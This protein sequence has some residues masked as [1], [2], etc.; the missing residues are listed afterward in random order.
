MFK[1]F[2]KLLLAH[3]ETFIK[4]TEKNF[5]LSFI[6]QLVTTKLTKHCKICDQCYL[7]FDHH[8]LFLLKCVA[9]SNHVLFVWLLILAGINMCLYCLGFCLYIY[10]LYSNMAYADIFWNIIHKQAWPFS[11]MCLNVASTVWSFSLVCQQ[12]MVV[13]KGFTSYFSGWNALQFRLT[14]YQTLSNFLHFLLYMPLPY[15]NPHSPLH[16]SAT[17]APVNVRDI[18]PQ[19]KGESLSREISVI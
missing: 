12:Y 1:L 3:V 19:R 7:H 11:L 10:I 5:W 8:C 15:T 2:I 13:T 14:W 6:L 17:A 9:G 18:P 4:Q 16:K